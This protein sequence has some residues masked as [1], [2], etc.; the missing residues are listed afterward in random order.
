MLDMENQSGLTLFELLIAVALF[1]IIMSGFYHLLSTALST[2]EYTGNNQELLAQGRYAMERIVMFGQEAEE[3]K[4]PA[5][6]KLEF[7]ERVLDTYDN[8]TQAY[9]VDGDGILDADRDADGLVDEG[10]GDNKEL[11]KFHHDK[12]AELL[13]EKLPD[14]G[15]ADEGDYRPDTV[16]CEHV[17]FF[18]VDKLSAELAE[19]QLTLKNGQS[20]V[21]LKTR[22]KARYVE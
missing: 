21:S 13:I 18:K 8:A 12:G 7:P 14:Y 17:T 20:E 22:V 9:C 2:Y 5:G 19:I 1:S 3:I 10:D 6:D 11:V 15:T 16:L 4:R